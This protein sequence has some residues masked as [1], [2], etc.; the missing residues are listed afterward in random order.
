VEGLKRVIADEQ[1]VKY[2]YNALDATEEMTNLLAMHANLEKVFPPEEQLD[3][4]QYTALYEGMEFVDDVT[5]LELD[6]GLAVKA[7]QTEMTYFK[8]RG[9][10]TKEARRLGMKVISTRWLDVNKGDDVKRD[11]R[12]RLV[13]RELN[14]SKRNDLFA[15]T[16]PLESLRAILSIAAGRQSSPSPRRRFIVMSN[17]VKRAYFYAPATRAVYIEVP[18]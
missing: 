2:V 16:P 13:G 17:D 1:W 11:Y 6:K 15:A 7:R 9:V 3:L 8:E 4:S 18:P 10:Y 14:L 5:G 12:A